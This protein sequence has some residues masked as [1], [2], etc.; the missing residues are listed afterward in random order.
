MCSSDLTIEYNLLGSAGG[1]FIVDESEFDIGDGVTR[2]AVTVSA[3][4][5]TNDREPWVRSSLAGNDLRTWRL[6]I[7]MGAGGTD[8]LDRSLPFTVVD[9]AVVLLRQ[10]ESLILTTDLAADG[11]DSTSL[12]GIA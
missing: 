8:K 2:V 3:R 10:D 9:S 7:G 1:Y 4:S 12:S 11:S 5:S 6:D